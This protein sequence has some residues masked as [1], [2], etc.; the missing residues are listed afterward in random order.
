MKTEWKRRRAEEV[1][2]LVLRLYL[3]RSVILNGMK[4]DFDYLF[5]GETAVRDGGMQEG[6]SDD[7]IELPIAGAC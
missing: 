6:I 5:P 1:F 7:I 2:G 4:D 3:I